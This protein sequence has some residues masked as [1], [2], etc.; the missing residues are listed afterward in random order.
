MYCVTVENGAVDVQIEFPVRGNPQSRDLALLPTDSGDR[1]SALWLDFSRR[2]GGRAGRADKQ[3]RWGGTG[4][5]TGANA[6][7]LLGRDRLAGS[8]LH[9][10]VPRP[11]PVVATATATAGAL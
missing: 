9:W 4:T 3:D 10:G 8:N 11:M 2:R 5:G 6:G 1:K 7:E